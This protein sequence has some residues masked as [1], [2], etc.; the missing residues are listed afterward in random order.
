LQAGKWTRSLGER[1]RRVRLFQRRRD[2]TFYRAEWAL[3]E[4]K[5][6]VK[7][8]HTSDRA[9]AEHLGRAIL[10]KLLEPQPTAARG[11][12]TLRGLW[13]RY[14]PECP[15]YL[16]NSLGTKR[17]AESGAAVLLGFFS[18]DRD[19]RTLCAEDQAAYTAARRA[20]GI[21][22]ARRVSPEA[23]PGGLAK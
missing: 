23:G 21:T 17:D 22:Y 16:D 1:G 19:V 5:K 14:E 20:G 8:L 10:A 2:G 9:E 4:H 3:G 11:C 15:T 18:P 7:C 12:V 6:D 13:E